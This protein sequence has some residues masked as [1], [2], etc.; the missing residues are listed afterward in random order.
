M[1]PDAHLLLLLQQV[2]PEVTEAAAQPHLPM[3]WAVVAAVLAAWLQ[4]FAIST[5][6]RWAAFL[7]CNLTAALVVR[8]MQADRLA[9]KRPQAT[10][11]EGG[12][13]LTLLQASLVAA[14]EVQQVAS[15]A[16]VV[17]RRKGERRGA[18]EDQLP[19]SFRCA[20][21]AIPWQCNPIAG[22]PSARHPCPLHL[23]PCSSNFCCPNP[24]LCPNHFPSW[25]HPAHCLPPMPVP[26]YLQAAGGQASR[27]AG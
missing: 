17:G 7:V 8:R 24:P 4:L 22:W 23:R 12:W 18:A 25:L 6:A 9:S 27:C 13:T 2:S 15:E 3:V 1:S 26:V 20:A 11:E 10:A 19:Q 21:C 5:A 16:G 14:A